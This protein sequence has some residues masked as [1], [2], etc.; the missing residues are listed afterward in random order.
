MLTNLQLFCHY[1]LYDYL[2]SK[3]R[4]DLATEIKAEIRIIGYKS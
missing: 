3:R 1:S 2:L 4:R